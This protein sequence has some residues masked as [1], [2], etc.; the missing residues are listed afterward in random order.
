MSCLTDLNSE[1]K[2]R[3]KLFSEMFNININTLLL[4]F[5]DMVQFVKS[6]QLYKTL[7]EFSSEKAKVLKLCL[8]IIGCIVILVYRYMVLQ[9]VYLQGVVFA[10]PWAQLFYVNSF[11]F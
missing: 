1:M 8:L 11:Y 5:L 6:L 9:I 3:I 4:A 10:I 2:T 7:T